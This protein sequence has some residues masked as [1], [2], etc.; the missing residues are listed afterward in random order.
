MEL[1]LVGQ[2]A[3]R[4]VYVMSSFILHREDYGVASVTYEAIYLK[5][6]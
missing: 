6:A 5:E 4:D 1:I 3:A 2:R